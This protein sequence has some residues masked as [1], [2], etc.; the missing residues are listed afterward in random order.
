MKLISRSTLTDAKVD[1][2]PLLQKMHA[3]GEVFHQPVLIF[4]PTQGEKHSRLGLRQIFESIP[5]VLA[6]QEQSQ[7]DHRHR[8]Q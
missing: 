8:P 1:A 7:D 2:N 4:S 3:S 5:G 6:R